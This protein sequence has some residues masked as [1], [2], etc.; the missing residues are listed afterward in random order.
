MALYTATPPV[1][2]NSHGSA[3]ES[4]PADLDTASHPIISRHWFGVES[5]TELISDALTSEAAKAFLEQLPSAEALM[6]MLE[7]KQVQ[8]LLEQGDR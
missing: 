3:A 2:T 6:P 1:A 7:L 5:Q 4:V 8:G